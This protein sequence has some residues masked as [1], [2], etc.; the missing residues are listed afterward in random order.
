[1]SRAQAAANAFLK[2]KYTRGLLRSV[3]NALDRKGSRQ[4]LAVL[5]TA[6]AKSV[7][8]AD[9]A[10]RYD[11]DLWSHRKND[12]IFPDG[13]SFGYDLGS[14]NRWLNEPEIYFQTVKTYWYKM[15]Q[16]KP[17]DVVLD[18]GA[19]RGE[20]TLSF[21][22]AVGNQGRVLAIESHP[23]SFRLLNKLCEANHMDNVLPVHA[24]VADKSG[25][26]F[27][28]ESQN[29]EWRADTVNGDGNGVAVDSVTIDQLC[30]QY[31]IDGIAFMK[32]NIEGAERLALPG[33]IESLSR[34]DIVCISCHDFLADR[35]LGESYRTRTFVED[36]LVSAGFEIVEFPYTYDFE[37]DHIHA[38][39]RAGRD[40]DALPEL[41]AQAV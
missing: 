14:M 41:A 34:T 25:T 15:Y 35:G 12:W 13:E 16:P 31:H 20:D 27:V 30:G 38:R 6:Y 8:R 3:I 40:A 10:V 2:R 4:A 28:A 17:G 29:G 37:R 24:A 19:G 5:Y 23:Y 26:M 7:T 21:S 32:M 11:G 18:V 22:R 1:M 36:F 39:R 33:M 9:V